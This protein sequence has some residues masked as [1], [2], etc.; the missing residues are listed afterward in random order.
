M[1]SV[2]ILAFS[3]LVSA[4]ATTGIVINN[5]LLPKTPEQRIAAKRAEN[6]IKTLDQRQYAKMWSYLGTNRR[7]E[8]GNLKHLERQ[9]LEGMAIVQKIRQI[10]QTVTVT[11]KQAGQL[12]IYA[13][14]PVAVTTPRGILGLIWITRWLFEKPQES[15]RNWYLVYEDMRPIKLT[16]ISSR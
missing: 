7:Q 14:T 1:R 9:F 5:Q 12:M 6:Y 13:E 8:A 15:S 10:G 11:E 2:A 4:C 16:A 3:L